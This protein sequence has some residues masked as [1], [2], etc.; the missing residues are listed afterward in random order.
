MAGSDIFQYIFFGG[1]LVSSIQVADLILL[2]RHKESIQK[3]ADNL[4]AMLQRLRLPS[5]PEILSSDITRIAISSILA[6]LILL[7]AYDYV[8]SL[9]TEFIFLLK[10]RDIRNILAF[11]TFVVSLYLGLMFVI[12]GGGRRFCAFLTT[13]VLES[14][15]AL[16]FFVRFGVASLV[17]VA[18]LLLIVIFLA[19]YFYI[20]G[21]AMEAGMGIYSDGEGMSILGLKF[22]PVVVFSYISFFT[23]WFTLFLTPFLIYFVA[24][25]LVLLPL[26][27]LLLANVA[28]SS[29][30]VIIKTLVSRIASFS[31][32]PVAA[33]VII[34]TFCSGVFAFGFEGRA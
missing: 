16:L 15:N 32:G 27:L 22:S 6:A 21:Q 34:I 31:Q 14:R 20:A 3:A 8:H 7:A 4:D 13:N 33:V 19:L 23:V 30:L 1:I 12:H 18:M 26:V 17:L 29:L 11:L 28:F 9:V 5:T 10:E 25:Y 2:D 24:S